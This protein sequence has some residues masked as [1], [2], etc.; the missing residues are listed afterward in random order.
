MPRRFFDDQNFHVGQ[1]VE[2]GA[3]ASHH[4][5]KVL[6]MAVA[7]E[8][9][10]FNG[11]GGEWLA[12]ISAISKK[13]VCIEPLT[14][15][16]EDRCAPLAVTVAL[17]MIKGERMDYAIQK[18]T[19][20]GATALVILD[21]ERCEV[22]LKGERQE[23]KLGHWQQVAISACEQ[24]GLNRVPVVHGVLSLR[25]WLTSDLPALKLIAHPGEK[26]FSAAALQGQTELALLTGPEGGFSNDELQQAADAGFSPFALGNRVLR[27]ETAPVA[28]LAA[29]WAWHGH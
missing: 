9:V 28:L 12:R 29:L 20:L 6:R 16:D 21:T 26:S 10:V 11:R 25:D 17:P 2:L 7:D 27:A 23:K 14:F 19:E 3:S 22:R 5:G 4:I 1:L 15:T 18:A 8:L 24:C 13:A